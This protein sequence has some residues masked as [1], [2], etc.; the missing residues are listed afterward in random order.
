MERNS[1]R[2]YILVILS[3]LLAICIRCQALV[4][5]PIVE[6]E[7]GPVQGCLQST[8]YLNV[9]FSAFLGI[10]YAEPPVRE[11]RFRP[12]VPIQ[13][14]TEVFDATKE[15]P[16]C[17]QFDKIFAI[18]TYMGDE[19]C[20]YLN[21]YTPLLDFNSTTDN[22]CPVIVWFY[23]GGFAEGYKNQSV[24]GPDF[25]MQGSCVIIVVSNYRIGCLGFLNL[26]LP[27]AHGNAGMMDQVLTLKWVQKNIAKFG[28]DPNNVT[29]MGQSAGSS[30]VILHELSP[31]SK[32]LFH[33]SIGQSGAPLILLSQSP[34]AALVSAFKL[35]SLFGVYT[36]D[37]KE[38]MKF[39]LTANAHDLTMKASTMYIFPDVITHQFLASIE[40]PRVA[41]ADEIFLS[42][43]PITLMMEGQIHKGPKMLGFN[44]N[45]L[46]PFAEWVGFSQLLDLFLPHDVM[47]VIVREL[48]QIITNITMAADTELTQRFFAAHNDD[49][50]VYYNILTYTGYPRHLATS[51]PVQRTAHGDDLGL[52]FN[53]HQYGLTNSTDPNDPLNVFRQKYVNL[54]VNFATSGNPTP[55]S[56]NPVQA[57]WEPSGS[58]GRQFQIDKE[59][60]M[61]NRALGVF[62]AIVQS[63]Y[64]FILPLCSSCYKISYATPY[65][66]LFRLDEFISFPQFGELFRSP[67]ITS[68]LNPE[69][70]TTPLRNLDLNSIMDRKVVFF[71]VLLL[72]RVRCQG[73]LRTDIIRTA[74]GPV[75]G[76][77]QQTVLKNISYSTFKGIP[78]AE[79]P[80]GN[81]R[82]KPPV[83]VKPWTAVLDATEEGPTCPQIDKVFRKNT[84]MG[85]EDCLSLN[86][87]TPALD[88]SSK[89]KYPVM[90]WIYGGAFVEGYKNQSLYGPDLFIE[91]GVIIVVPNYRLG[92][93]GFLSLGIPEAL[94]N[95][96]MK[97]QVL[98]L[99]WV[100][101]NI[102][103]FG[104]D[105][106]NVTLFGESSGSSSVVLH[107]LSPQSKGLY[108]STISQSGAPLIF[109][110]HPPYAALKSAHLLAAL[111]GFDT[112]NKEQ[113]FQSFLHAN[114]YDLVMATSN[115]YIVSDM[116]TR[117]FQPTV[118]DSSIASMDNIFLD[119][120]AITL[121]MNG[122]I[123][124][125]PK[126]IGFT[127][128]EL[129][130]FADEFIKF[131]NIV[132]PYMKA[133]IS[134]T[135]SLSQIVSTISY[136]AE[137][138]LT[139][140]FLAVHN[141]DHPVYF[142]IITY[143]DF[144]RHVITQ[145]QWNE[146]AHGDDIN[147][148]FTITDY[149]LATTTD[150]NH[151][152][153]IFRRK[154]V[155]LWTNFAK[156]GNPTPAFANPIDIIWE[157]SGP[158]GR[159]LDINSPFRMIDR[160]LDASL[161]ESLYYY[162]LPIIS[163]CKTVSYATPYNELF[164][165][166]NNAS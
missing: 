51:L 1:M 81:F 21:V 41:S 162:T 152:L 57:I 108:Q 72:T 120:C 82:F 128:N 34:F 107:E 163:G 18:D 68:L 47:V 150:P 118:E 4:K 144:P 37:R 54:I 92:V 102:A 62:G 153:N 156:Y 147:L 124:K 142:Y 97:D 76:Y 39:Y 42:E 143:T 98:A 96:G 125:G 73:F 77:V 23:G 132:I 117:P 136:T 130:G 44:T 90:V 11:L 164:L 2:E 89:D 69:T 116:L 113:L 88:L 53:N 48:T 158:A 140:R 95:A 166:N 157:P 100:Q 78:F 126:M 94:G 66:D 146:T 145:L 22:K 141:G 84:Y 71:S 26:G 40:D 86:V 56:N 29:I 159:Q 87:Y 155:R 60:K 135:R 49:Q 161:P 16:T 52:L 160:A 93:L 112:S 114:V 121:L 74:S 129:F 9:T 137:I 119:E 80:I 70:I 7:S 19:D 12:P 24:Y 85:D 17:P 13:P 6:T 165:S 139:Q 33:K 127:H 32:G 122:H 111:L 25:F 148:L 104:G 110:S 45:E 154:M 14:W 55:I 5:T 151:S 36:L 106:N 38:L 101:K 3:I 133:A 123:R 79:P 30:S 31:Q 10:P 75:R 58:S 27:E 105:P 50:P 43:C 138:D 149:G 109:L 67:N 131:V 28:G 35:A 46:Y 91:E 103:T 61:I 8:A 59:S 15:R 20:L 99:K 83:P 63:I 134:V 65:T 64:Y 115:M